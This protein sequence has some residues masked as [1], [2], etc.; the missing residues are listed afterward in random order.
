MNFFFFSTGH[1]Y[2]SFHRKREIEAIA[3]L[4]EIEGGKVVYFNKPRFF[5]KK[6]KTTLESKK[7]NIHIHEILILFPVLL[8]FK[9]KFLMYLLVTM[10]IKWQLRFYAYKYG[11]KRNTI[12]SWLYKPDQYIYLP[13]SY[14][15]VYLHY[16]NYVNDENYFLSQLPIFNVALGEC[17]SN[18]VI[19]LFTSGRIMNELKLVD[20]SN[21][22]F[23]YPNAIDRSLLNENS[24][25]ENTDKKKVI[26]FI[27]QLDGSFDVSLVEKLADN[28][29]FYDFLLVGPI[30]NNVVNEKLGNRKN[31]NLVGYID[32]NLL[33]NYLNK[34]DIGICPYLNDNF[35]K[36]RN[37][38]KVIEYFSF[39]IP[40]VCNECDVDKNAIPMLKMAE[41]EEQF[42]ES[43][44]IELV[45]S[46][47]NKT[48]QRKAYAYTNC[49]DN[50]AEFLIEKLKE[51]YA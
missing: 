17:I 34:F 43:I 32:Y 41:N 29:P 36:Y 30:K 20:G 48:A 35:N 38:L 1:D 18:S 27:G 22:N 28:Y 50:R 37:P 31:V 14:P 24:V 40:V 26:G 44:Q 11:L 16:D 51:A 49:W 19:S 47:K 15:F 10:P 23:Y 2:H 33:K 9:F 39:G 5:L 8:S 7:Q 3:D 21:N 42:I 25:S 13:K 45:S 6:K 12:T 46:S 4:V